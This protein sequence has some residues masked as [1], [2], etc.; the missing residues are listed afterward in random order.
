[1]K[2]IIFV[3]NRKGGDFCSESA[4]PKRQWIVWSFANLGSDN[5]AIFCDDNLFVVE[6]DNCGGVGYGEFM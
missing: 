1:M 6:S 4:R 5:C 3:P 2:R